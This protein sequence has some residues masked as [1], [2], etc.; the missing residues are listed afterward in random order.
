M[1]TGQDRAGAPEGLDRE[2]APEG[3][4]ASLGAGAPAD[5]PAPDRR[6]PAPPYDG[7]GPHALWHVSDQSGI[8]RFDPRVSTARPDEK[9]V[10]AVDTR[11][12][13]LFWFP[14]DC[15][16]GTFWAGERTTDEHVEFFLS[17][18]RDVRVHA[19]DTDW[20]PQM[21]AAQVIAYRMPEATFEPDPV[22]TGYWRSR[23]AVMP[24]ETV[25]LD[26]LIGRHERA[27]IELRVVLDLWS[28]WDRIVASTLE[29]S[30]IRL[31]NAV[32]AR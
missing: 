7:E 26:D 4:G 22:V 24:L 25:A 19:V 32:R 17:G 12:L 1:S 30:G 31:R 23:E 2:G 16:R 29:F 5:R 28:V 15:P 6:A 27:G 10:W 14:R 13:P 11:H 9:L 3:R 18:R 8:P 20:L 21:R